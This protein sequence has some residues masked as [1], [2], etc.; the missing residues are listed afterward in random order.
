MGSACELEYQ[1]LLAQDLGYIQPDISESID[2]GI[3]EVKRML[4]ALIKKLQSPE[5]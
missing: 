2:Q 3:G 5:G 1:V 4:A